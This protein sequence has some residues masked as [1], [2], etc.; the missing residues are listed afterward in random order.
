MESV[1]VRFHKVV[2]AR[3]KEVIP[4]VLV[5]KGYRPLTINDFSLH[6]RLHLSLFSSDQ[7]N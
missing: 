3:M 4:N 2:P 6:L 1:K 7:P 5:E